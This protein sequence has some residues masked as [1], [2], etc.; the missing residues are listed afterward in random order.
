[1]Y[2]FHIRQSA[3]WSNGDPVTAYDFAF[4]WKRMLDSPAEYTYLHYY[5]EGAEEYVN[6][7][8][9]GQPVDIKNVG[10]EAVD[11]HTFRVTLHDPVPFMMDLM[12]YT[13]FYPLNERSMEP[14]KQIDP[15]TGKTT[16]NQKFTRPP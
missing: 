5:I 7:S 1:V 15:R 3:R 13:P 10:E 14:F 6:R 9:K 8:A 11:A 4:S 16:Y 2:A 12:A